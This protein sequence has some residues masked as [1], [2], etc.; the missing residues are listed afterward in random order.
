LHAAREGASVKRLIVTGDDFGAST[1]VNEAIE[2]AHRGGVLNTTCLM[3]SGAAV[4]DAVRRA[5]RLPGLR[6]GL[7]V[8]VVDGR[9]L[10]DPSVVPAL[11]DAD[12]AF[13]KQLVRAGFTMFFK[14]QARAQLE[15]EIRA[16]FEAFA[17]TGLALDHVNGHNHMQVHPTVLDAIIRI[18]PAYGM[19]AVRVPYEP[20]GPSWR[21][22]RQGLAGR[23]GN[24]VG[25]APVMAYCRR[26]LREA[27][28]AFNDYVFGL[29]DTGR[30]TRER[31][32]ALL[33]E[34]PDG[35]TEM[36]F[37]PASRRAPGMPAYAQPEAELAALLDPAVPACI[38]DSNIILSTYSQLEPVPA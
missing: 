21:A 2:Q 36:Y 37:H 15:D 22:A 8:V 17:T 25:L 3:M 24:S 11:V 10:L 23:A 20:L 9:P 38:A 26:R 28:I 7:H 31:V 16:Q 14:P 13:S 6:V 32:L 18:G 4:D 19:K 27:G 5:K 35:V 12:G 29:S 33:R 34:L 1:L 30:M